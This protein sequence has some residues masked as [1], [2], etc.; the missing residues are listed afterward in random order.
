MALQLVNASK[1]VM[2][3]YP[4]LP[5]CQLVLIALPEEPERSYGEPSLE[6]KYID[7]D[8]GPSFWWRDRLVKRILEQ[9][10]EKDYSLAAQDQL[11]RLVGGVEIE[12][13]DRLEKFVSRRRSIEVD[14]IDSMV[15]E[16]AKAENRSRILA[17]LAIRSPVGGFIVL[18]GASISVVFVR[19]FTIGHWILWVVTLLFA[20]G[21]T[22]AMTR[23]ERAWLTTS[24]LEQLRSRMSKN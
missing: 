13:I 16:F 23:G 2:V 1:S 7:D 14:S 20:V 3:L 9:L 4:G 19:P 8:G 10:H 17:L 22:W 6:S 21:A 5:I 12:V 15:D 18:L 11:I 24:R